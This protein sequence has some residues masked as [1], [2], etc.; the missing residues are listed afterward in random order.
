MKKILITGCGSGLGRE[1]AIALAHRGHYVYAT[2]H[3]KEQADKLNTLNKK[4][5]LPLE[6]F[7]L[8]ILCKDDRLKVMDIHI[9]VLINNAAI[10][11]SGS[12][13]EIDVNSY[14]NTFETNV[15]SPI[16]LTQ[17]VLKQMIKR[18]EGRI[19]FLSS[20]AGRSPIPFLSPYCATKFALEAI[21]P[22]LNEELKELRDVNIPVILIEPGS[23]ATGFNQKNISKQFNWMNI[24]SYFKH[25][26]RSLQCRQYGYFK[27]TESTN[28][29]SIVDK[30]IKAVE[31]KYPK[32]RYIS[33]SSQGAFI[34]IKNILKK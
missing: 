10:G 26:L 13:A 15:F 2:T 5:N 4:Y 16:E 3:T 7:K 6:S 19:I 11:D 1:A 29:Y 17:L 21:G 8:D 14:R 31:D 34:K 27:L 12:V 18:K 32:E 28:F 25:N 20:L 9:D 24:N 23:Y 22:S 33:P 30:Y